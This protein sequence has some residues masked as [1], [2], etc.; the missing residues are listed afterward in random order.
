MASTKQV[1]ALIVGAGQRGSAYASFA[2]DFPAKLQ[3]SVGNRRIAEMSKVAGP[4][5]VYFRPGRYIFN[6]AGPTG[7]YN[8]G[9]KF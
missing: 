7:R 4:W 3:V 8:L 6:L 5:P 9:I 2:L 1:H